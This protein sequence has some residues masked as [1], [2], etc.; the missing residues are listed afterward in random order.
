MSSTGV[1]ATSSGDNHVHIE[2]VTAN[3]LDRVLSLIR[4][5]VSGVRVL[6]G[7]SSRL[8]QSQGDEEEAEEEEQP[9]PPRRSTRL[10]RTP[11]MRPA[12]SK[13]PDWWMKAHTEPQKV[14]QEL[15]RSGEFG[16]IKP[17]LRHMSGRSQ[18]LAKL[19][20]DRMADVRPISKET[21]CEVCFIRN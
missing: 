12:R 9:R 17:K 4:T 21:L 19:M 16:E 20:R 2:N 10:L 18:N 1:D 5:T 3:N 7:S 8:Q 13:S 14:G 11:G 6:S 15:L